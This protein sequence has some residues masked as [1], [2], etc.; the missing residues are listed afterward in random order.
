M[1]SRSNQGPRPLPRKNR[2]GLGGGTP[3]T[4]WGDLGAGTAEPLGESGGR[5]ARNPP[6]QGSL[7]VRPI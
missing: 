4:S 2:W 1:Y 6:G 5:N 3:Q 7:G